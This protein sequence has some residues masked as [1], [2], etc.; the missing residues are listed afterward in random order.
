MK[1]VAKFHL[2]NLL[3]ETLSFAVYC[4]YAIRSIGK[5]VEKAFR[6]PETP[7]HL[8]HRTGSQDKHRL[9]K[10]HAHVS[11]DVKASLPSS[12][13]GKSTEHSGTR[14]SLGAN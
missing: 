4:D 6:S 3:K 7:G 11:V 10:A 1:P 2:R 9:K 5:S 8:K 14:R 12:R 13:S